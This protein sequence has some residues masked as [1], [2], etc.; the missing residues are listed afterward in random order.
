M[1]RRNVLKISASALAGLY[2]SPLF[3]QTRMLNN[4]VF[5]CLFINQLLTKKNVQL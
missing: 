4:S 5:K 2:L 3:S 1:N